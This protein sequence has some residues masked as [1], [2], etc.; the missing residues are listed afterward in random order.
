MVT[1]ACSLLEELA[2]IN[3]FGFIDCVSLAVTRLSRVK[4]I[5]SL[6]I[7]WHLLCFQIVTASHGDF[8]DYTYYFVPAPW[9]TVKLLRLLQCFEIPGKYCM[10]VYLRTYVW[11]SHYHTDDAVVRA[12]LSEALEA[13]LNRAQEPSKSKKIQYSNSKNSV[14]FEGINLILHF[15]GLVFYTAQQEITSMLIL[16]WPQFA[17]PSMQ[18]I[19]WLPHT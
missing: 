8:Q 16:Q 9:L 10:Y 7:A 11:C 19:G 12:R 13:I 4:L 14:L 15:Q 5:V 3:S 2:H 17:S 18:L 6:H 1:A